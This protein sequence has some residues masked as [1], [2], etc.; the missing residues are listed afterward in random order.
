MLVL[1]WAVRMG[2]LVS[3]HPG[4]SGM[5]AFIAIANTVVTIRYAGTD[6]GCQNW[7]SC[8]NIPGG[9]RYVCIH[10]NSQYCSSM[11]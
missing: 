2:P 4:D 10:S 3:I 9:F 7:A 8:I 1:T 6:M 11:N 5:Y